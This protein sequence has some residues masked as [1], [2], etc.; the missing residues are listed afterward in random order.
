M[1]NISAPSN[2]KVKEV[3]KLHSKKQRDLENLFIIEGEEIIKEIMD[4][5]IIE[6]LF[7]TDLETTYANAITVNDIVMKK[8]SQLKSPTSYLAVC[9][10]LEEKEIESNKV[11][12]LENVQD[13]GN[14]G[15]MIRTASCFG[16]KDVVLTEDSADIYNI[17]TIRASMGS[18]FK[19]NITRKPIDKVLPFLKSNKYKLIATSLTDD[20][21]S[22]TKCDPTEKFAV[23]LGNEG[24][25]LT[26]FTLS[27]CDENVIVPIVDND[28][29]NVAIAAGI[30]LYELTK[31]A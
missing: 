31:N 3:V 6:K 28:S 12:V 14:I 13:P 20:A 5:D 19:L 7:T 8:M 29:L 4:L 16:I 9:K 18:M 11:L 24:K 27:A 15:T 10:K 23:L 17:K 2:D 21:I 1:I 26:D 22:V 30:V 25:G